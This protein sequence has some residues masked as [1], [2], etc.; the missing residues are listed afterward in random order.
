VEEA[1]EEAADEPVEEAIEEAGARPEEAAEEVTE[2]AA[3]EPLLLEELIDCEARPEWVEQ[4]D[5]DVGPVHMISVTS[6]PFTRRQ[7]ARRTL[8]RLLKETTDRYVNKLIGA[9]NAARW[10]GW[11]E[12]RIRQ[13]L[14]GPDK[15]YDETVNSPSVGVMHQSHALLEFD[16]QFRGEME[17]QWKHVVARAQLIKVTLVGGLILGML[18]LLFGYFN[19]DTATRGF[20]TGRLKFVTLVAI[21]GLVVF[22]VLLARSIPWIWL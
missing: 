15:V 19:A 12:A 6:G 22:G 7:E 18:V 8:Y 20:Y 16:E 4:A 10:I 2:E 1:A 5:V 11:S 9:P 13:T 3:D 21:L 17:T 14:V